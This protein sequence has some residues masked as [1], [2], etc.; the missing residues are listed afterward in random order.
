[1]AQGSSVWGLILATGRG[2]QLTSGA[3]TAFLGI[4]SRPALAHVLAAFEGCAEIEA[5]VVVAARERLDDVR[6]LNRRFGAAKMA[7]VVP[8]FQARRASV[9]AGL[10]ALGEDAAFVVVHDAARPCVKPAQ[11]AAVA[12]AARRH[13]NGVMA[14]QVT[15]PVVEVSGR[16]M[17]SDRGLWDRAI[18]T[19]QTPQCYRR[20]LLE[21]MLK[22]ADR[23]RLKIEDEAAA[24]PL[25]G[26][27]IR[28]VPTEFLNLRLRA[29]DDLALAAQLLP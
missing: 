29:A 15:E 3:E 6:A 4:G 8:G 28:L 13:G 21:K 25:V 2:Q 1:M 18:W 22:A 23:K 12:Q 19:L 20:E 27:S 5:V 26:E 11:I 7:R 17:K 9:R 16:A 10:E 24:L 14:A